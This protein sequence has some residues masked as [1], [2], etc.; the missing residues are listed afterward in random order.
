MLSNPSGDSIVT[1]WEKIVKYNPEVLIVAPCGFHIERALKEIVLLT[2]K[3]GWNQLQAVVN[4][5][6]YIVDFD[7]FTQPSAST[8]VDGIEILAALFHPYLFKVPAH[9]EHKFV[10]LF[11]SDVVYASA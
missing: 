4:K 9:L 10:N 11:K 7:L 5:Q 3:G 1:V 8:L 6:V 2:Q